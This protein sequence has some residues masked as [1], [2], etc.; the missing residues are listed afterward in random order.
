MD[1]GTPVTVPKHSREAMWVSWMLG[2]P[3]ERRILRP[4]WREGRE[5]MSQPH[6]PLW[7]RSQARLLESPCLTFRHRPKCR[8]TQSAFIPGPGTEGVFHVH[9]PS[10]P[11]VPADF[12]QRLCALFSCQD[13]RPATGPRPDAKPTK[14]EERKAL[15]KN[16][17]GLTTGTGTALHVLPILSVTRPR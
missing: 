15:R 12:P 17:Q 9:D 14:Q 16:R 4:S 7:R 10:D 3:L 5:H 6:R 2:G 8:R 13:A 1:T 11:R